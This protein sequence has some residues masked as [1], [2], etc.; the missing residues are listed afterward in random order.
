MTENPAIKV[1]G[2][3]FCHLFNFRVFTFPDAEVGPADR[4]LSQFDN[5]IIGLQ[6]F[7]DGTFFKTD[8]IGAIVNHCFHC[9]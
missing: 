8:V 3:F 7:R 1:A 6:D 5:G 9:I 4:D 2:F